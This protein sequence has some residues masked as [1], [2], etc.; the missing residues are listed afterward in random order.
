MRIE[1]ARSICNRLSDGRPALTI[2]PQCRYLIKVLAGDWRFKQKRTPMGMLSEDTEIDK[3]PHTRPSSDL[4]DAFAYL[5][6]ASGE[7][8][9]LNAI[10]RPKALKGPLCAYCQQT[11]F[12]GRC[13]CKSHA[14]GW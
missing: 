12:L 7:A 2:D 13:G 10:A 6:L 1:A 8:G 9:I 4:G 3:G 11:I 5:V 14:Y